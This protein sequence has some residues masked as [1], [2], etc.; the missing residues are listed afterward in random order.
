MFFSIAKGKLG[1][2]ILPC[3]APL[4]VLLAL[5]LSPTHGYPPLRLATWA[6]VLFAGLL[7]AALAAFVIFSPEDRQLFSAD[8][9]YKPIGLIGAL[10]IWASLAWR[11]RHRCGIEAI[12][13][14]VLVPLVFMLTLPLAAPGSPS[15]SQTPEAFITANADRIKDDTL[16]L[17]NHGGLATALAW[18]FLRSEIILYHSKSELSYGLA[19]PDASGRYIDRDGLSQWLQQQRKRHEIALFLRLNRNR[20]PEPLPPA[21]FESRQ[22][23]F[24]L[25]FYQRRS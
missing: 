25:V 9:R 18:Q 13:A 4:A 5:G 3:F 22:G 23:R 1:T 24:R 2:Y 19:Y 8:E 7:A 21:D 17:S 16:L 14:F 20:D 11:T 15:Y 12:A 10:L 6:N